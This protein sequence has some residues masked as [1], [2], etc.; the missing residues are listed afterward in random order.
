MESSASAAGRRTPPRFE[1]GPCRLRAESAPPTG[2]R[3]VE[4]LTFSLDSLVSFLDCGGGT[5]FGGIKNCASDSDDD[6]PEDA[7]LI[8]C[9]RISGIAGGLTGASNA[10][11][12]TWRELSG[13]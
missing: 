2:L 1:A 13:L 12:R 6:S 3:D 5:T 7:E 10:C 11:V 4:L 8:V 9:L